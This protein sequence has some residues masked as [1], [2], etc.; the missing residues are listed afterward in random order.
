[1]MLVGLR[2]IRG[3]VVD[4]VLSVLANR[5]QSLA[6]VSCTDDP[7]YL[8]QPTTNL[9]DTVTAIMVAAA[10]HGDILVPLDNCGAMAVFEIR[11]C[12]RAHAV[13]S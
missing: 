3:P 6:L 8:L 9:S 5:I 11:F 4:D 1:M 10:G 2:K 12:A 7:D 13:L